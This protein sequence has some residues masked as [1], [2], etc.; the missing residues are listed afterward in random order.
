MKRSR[1]QLRRLPRSRQVA[2]PN[3]ALLSFARCRLCGAD[4]P[5]TL[6]ANTRYHSECRILINR[7][8]KRNTWHK[9]KEY[10][11]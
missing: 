5:A 4:L 10:Y 2:K 11:R 9:R 8:H 1:S 7:Q 3:L 6:H